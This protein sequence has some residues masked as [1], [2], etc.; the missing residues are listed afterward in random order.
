MNYLTIYPTTI[1]DGPGVRV[2]IYVSGCHFHCKGCHNPESWN[3]NAGQEFTDETLETLFNYCNHDYIR[4]LSILGGEPLNKNNRSVV[5]DIIV[6][7][8]RR[9]PNKDLWIWTGYEYNDLTAE[10]TALGQAPFKQAFYTLLNILSN[11]DVLVVGQFLLDKRD[12]TKNNL[13]RGST[14][15][16]VIDVKKSLETNSCVY[17]DGIPNNS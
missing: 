12:I 14:N 7:F 3:F 13:Y 6:D 8:K 4:G 10:L 2:S 15:Q 11:T 5:R 16:R 9:F 1:A 17:L